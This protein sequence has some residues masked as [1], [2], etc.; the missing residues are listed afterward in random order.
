MNPALRR[1]VAYEGGA[2]KAKQFELAAPHLVEP[3]SV[4]VPSRLPST[5]SPARSS[6]TL[7]KY[8]CTGPATIAMSPV[9]AKR[10]AGF[11][12]APSGAAPV[13]RTTAA[14]ERKRPLRTAGQGS[15]WGRPRGHGASLPGSTYFFG[16]MTS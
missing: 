10:T 8:D 14:A 6:E 3:R 12:A 11:G 2:W 13:S 16:R 1:Y 9:K 15:G 7:L 4:S 5:T